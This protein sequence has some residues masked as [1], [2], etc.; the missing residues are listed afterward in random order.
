MAIKTVSKAQLRKPR[1][2]Q[3]PEPEPE[4]Q[5]V[6]EEPEIEAADEEDNLDEDQI[7]QLQALCQAFGGIGGSADDESAQW[8]KR[9]AQELHALNKSVGA[10]A[11]IM[12]HNLRRREAAAKPAAQPQQPV[13]RTRPAK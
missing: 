10:I 12:G 3:A 5:R 11:S 4:P 2:V 13:Q 9:I 7:A 6:V 8:I 1:V